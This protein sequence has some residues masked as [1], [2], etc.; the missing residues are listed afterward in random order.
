[1]AMPLRGGGVKG[2][3]FRFF[4]FVEKV[5]TA[6]KTAIKTKTFFVVS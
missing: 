5:P 4:L 3:P 2:L 1:M 6:I